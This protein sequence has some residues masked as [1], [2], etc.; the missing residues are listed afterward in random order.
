MISFKQDDQ[1]VELPKKLNVAPSQ[2][3][4]TIPNEDYHFYRFFVEEQP[5]K[6][7]K[8]HTETASD[9]VIT[10]VNKPKSPMSHFKD[11]MKTPDMTSASFL[12][13]KLWALLHMYFRS[14]I[15]INDL[16]SMKNQDMDLENETFKIHVSE[17]KILT[18][19]LHTSLV[20]I[21]NQYMLRRTGKPTD[22]LFCNEQGLEY[23]YSSCK[24]QI[25]RLLLQHELSNFSIEE[26]TFFYKEL[27]S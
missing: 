16:L 6:K 21:M 22:F 3:T 13:V 20:S 23:T 18:F 10:V 19:S 1:F 12:Q 15:D 25:A 11:L 24:A 5:L 4:E 27:F 26:L 2:S 17:T 9:S 8:L 14:G 7:E